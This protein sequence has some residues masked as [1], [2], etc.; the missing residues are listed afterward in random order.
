MFIRVVSL[1]ALKN[2]LEKKVSS[3]W[4]KEI[5]RCL[6]LA[7]QQWRKNIEMTIEDDKKQWVDDEKR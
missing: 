3:K 6:G 2:V 1:D 4:A 7:F 5:L